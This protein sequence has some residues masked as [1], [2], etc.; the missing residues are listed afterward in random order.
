MQA[1]ADIRVLD[2][3][4]VIAGPFCAYQ[5]AVMGADV[6]KIEPV[7]RADI[8]RVS[9]RAEH[10]M[11]PDFLAQNANK[12]AIALD[13]KQE[14]GREV[15]RALI[16]GADVFIENYRAGA[17]RT[18]GFDYARVKALREDIIYCSITG[19]GQ[20][21]ALAKRTA[22]DNVIQASSGLME[23]TG[24]AKSAPLKVGPPVLDYGSGMQA[25]FAIAAALYR[26]SREKAG[27]RIDVAM[28]DSALMLM[29]SHITALQCDGEAPR[30]SGNSSATHAGYAC[31]ET[32]DGLL[33]IGA[34]SG[35]QMQSLWRALGE[36]K[37]AE[38][39]AALTPAD[40]S[41]RMHTDAPRLQQLLRAK[42][43]DEW[44]RELNNAHV[45]AAKVRG[46]AHAIGG[47]QLKARA[48]L[49]SPPGAHMQLPAAAFTCNRDGPELRAPPPRHAQHTAEVLREAGYD[50]KA[51]LELARS[52]AVRLA[53]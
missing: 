52:G 24:D 42:S 11:A 51:V 46:L 45:P 13:L 9:A 4:H 21:G 33:M 10:G 27:Q 38:E 8:S 23:S 19:F 43:A 36:Q 50:E 17:M 41:A 37:R 44:E 32:A 26:R 7:T 16:R 48:V 20:Q 15:L 14:A 34:Y 29:S 31:Y 47:G 49:Q 40:M 12:R 35:A 28:L 6:I 3:T 18:L 39:V 5:L 25:A 30:A 2:L 22:Y 1:F 53:R